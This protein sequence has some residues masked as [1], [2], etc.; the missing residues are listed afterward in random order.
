MKIIKVLGSGCAK[1]KSTATLIEDSARALGIEVSVQKVQEPENIMA[2]G[3]MSTPAVVI[4]ETVVHKG[5]VPNKEQV[6]EWLAS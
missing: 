5:G 4:D 6:M 1:C 2:Y 3:V